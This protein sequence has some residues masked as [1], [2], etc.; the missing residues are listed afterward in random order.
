[1]ERESE[2]VREQKA[3]VEREIAKRKRQGEAFRRLEAPQGSRKLATTF[4]GRAWCE[5]LEAYAA[6]EHRLPRGRSYLRQG[7]VYDLEIEPGL[8]RATVEGA[9]LYE[10]RVRI[11]RL[12]RERWEAVLRACSGQVG[13]MLDLLAGKLGEGVLKVLTDSES[14]LFPGTDE[15]RFDCS[16]P[17]HADLCKHAAAVLFGV[18]VMLDA[19]PELFFTLRSVDGAELLA[20]GGR[21]VAEE[22]GGGGELAEEDL[23][24][25]FGIEL[26]E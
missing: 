26:G 5:H 10:T 14:G 15:I 7:K 2:E 16:C 11:R 19:R 23:G 3:R 12:E 22:L 4:W 9:E 18:G 6:Y 21:D 24:A 20:A 8:V 17:D 1:M 25:L 13:S